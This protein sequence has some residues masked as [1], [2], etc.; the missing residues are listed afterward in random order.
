MLGYDPVKT[1]IL[2]GQSRQDLDGLEK[3]VQHDLDEGPQVSHHEG[4]G[5]RLRRHDGMNR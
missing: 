3:K 2:V 5:K 1:R 4:G